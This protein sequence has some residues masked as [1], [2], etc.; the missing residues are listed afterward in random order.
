MSDPVKNYGVVRGNP[1]PFCIGDE[2][3]TVS[4]LPGQVHMEFTTWKIE[5]SRPV[6]PTDPEEVDS[7]VNYR[8]DFRTED[9]MLMDL[10]VMTLN[11]NLTADQ[12]QRFH[13]DKSW[14]LE[15]VSGDMLEELILDVMDPFLLHLREMQ[16]K[17]EKIRAE[18]MRDA[19]TP[20]IKELIQEEIQTQRKHLKPSSKSSG[21]A[22]ITTDG[23]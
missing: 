19:I 3:I 18:T 21:N 11:G 4:R 5:L 12:K 2:T 15:Y 20:M 7:G 10:A 1:R 23:A 16:I 13:I 9:E 14:I 6:K 22:A 8:S 17:Q